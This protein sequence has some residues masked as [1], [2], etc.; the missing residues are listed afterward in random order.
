MTGPPVRAPGGAYEGAGR[1]AG[2]AVR[3]HSSVIVASDDPVAAGHAAIGIALAEISHRLV[4][5]ADLAGETAPIQALVR[6]DDF[7]GV[8][9]SFTFGTSFVRVAREVEGAK[10][11]FVIPAGTES[12]AT[13]EILSSPRWGTFASEFATA[14]ELLILVADAQSA[15]IANLAAQVDGVILVGLTRLDAAPDAQIFAK[16]P[17][18]PVSR[19]PRIDIAPRAN[20]PPVAQLGLAAVALLAVGI[21]AGS[22]F[23][24]RVR[25]NGEATPVAPAAASADSVTDSVPN[26]RPG[27][28]VPA[29]AADSLSAVPFSVEILAS[30]T[31]EGANFEIQRHGSVMPAATI[32]LVP[33]G[34]TEATWYKVHAGAFA[35]S[36]QAERLLASLRRRRIVPDSAGSVVRAPLALLVDTIP[37]QAGMTSRIRDRLESLRLKGVNAYAMLQ[38]DGSARVYAG[39]FERAQQSSLAATALCVAGLEPVLVYRTGRT[40]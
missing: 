12:P 2:A 30:N 22:F 26:A 14:D 3:G 1:R 39:A 4:M 24:R 15:G 5:I 16:I 29:N 23:G 17:H 37:S 27:A 32:S 35:D 20:K 21:A 34:D 40:Q 28:I 38:N 8:Y 7:H 31:A 13:E 10:N 36:A 6:D 18:P 9:D 11:L 33:I 19:P 25:Q